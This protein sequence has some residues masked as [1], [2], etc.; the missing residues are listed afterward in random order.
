MFLIRRQ[1][2]KTYTFILF[3]ISSI[4]TYRLLR[5]RTVSENLPEIP[6]FGPS[7]INQLRL[8]GSQQYP[9]SGVFLK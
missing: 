6:L 3:K 4:G 7:L 2:R 9:Q 1:M 8:F 5:G